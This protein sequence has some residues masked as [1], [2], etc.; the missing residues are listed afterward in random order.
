M[1]NNVTKYELH[2][3]QVSITEPKLKIAKI[4]SPTRLPS[5]N[6]CDENKQNKQTDHEK[7]PKANNEILRKHFSKR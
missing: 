1:M 5:A 7:W 4:Y 6:A 2:H 3:V